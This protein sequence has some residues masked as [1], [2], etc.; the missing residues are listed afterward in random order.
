MD[1][2]LGNSS[3][4]LQLRLMSA[5]AIVRPTGGGLVLASPARAGDDQVGIGRALLEDEAGQQ[6]LNLRYTQ[7]D[8]GRARRSPFFRGVCR[9]RIAARKAWA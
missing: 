5:G 9:A 3:L 7:R 8:V 1:P 4:V 6:V 2:T